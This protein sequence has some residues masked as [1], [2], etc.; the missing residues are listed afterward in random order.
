LPLLDLL[1]MLVEPACIIV[2]NSA[3]T[4]QQRGVTLTIT[5]VEGVRNKLTKESIIYFFF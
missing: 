3:A 2:W 1:E 5:H 4:N